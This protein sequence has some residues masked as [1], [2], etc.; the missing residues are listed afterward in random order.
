MPNTFSSEAARG[1][2]TRHQRRGKPELRG[3]PRS[4]NLSGPTRSARSPS[5]RASA[6]CRSRARALR[7]FARI[8]R[9]PPSTGP[10]SKMGS[11]SFSLSSARS[12]G[13]VKQIWVEQHGAI[14]VPLATARPSS[15]ARGRT[16]LTFCTPAARGSSTTRADR[17]RAPGKSRSDLRRNS[18]SKPPSCSEA[19]F[20]DCR[21]STRDA[22]YL[23]LGGAG[24]RRSQ[25][26]R[27]KGGGYSRARRPAF[28]RGYNAA[29]GVRPRETPYVSRPF[30]KFAS[31]FW[32]TTISRGSKNGRS[33]AMTR[34][35]GTR[36]EPAFSLF[37][38]ALR[39]RQAQASNPK[40]STWAS[41]NAG[42]GKTHVL[43][44]R[45]VRLLLEGTPPAQI[46]CLAY[47]KAAAANMAD[48]Y[49][50]QLAGWTSLETRA[51]RRRSSKAARQRQ[52]R[53][54]RLR[55]AI[56]RPHDRDAGRAQ[57]SDAACLRR[58]IA[59]AF[60]VRGQCPGAFQGHRRERSS[61]PHARGARPGASG[62][63]RGP[64]EHGEARPGG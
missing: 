13:E 58:A 43:T 61:P 3:T 4:R 20:Q 2:R 64:G 50:T 5:T 56:V 16:E 55:A 31:R 42:S 62:A 54:A 38:A 35:R 29:R 34:T 47:T 15:S 23:K 48:A 45:V 6:S 44:Q 37:P 51:S 21:R 22:L 8:R 1:G 49:F 52:A 39:E 28:R 7:R 17:R 57:D 25:T 10:M 32:I 26:R 53:R 40:T 27:R 36:R 12:R 30:P 9:L 46:L 59:Q 14:P 18:R 19:V 11:T 24:G 33:Q 41:A 60:S 63:E